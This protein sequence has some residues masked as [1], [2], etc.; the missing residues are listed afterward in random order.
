MQKYEVFLEGVNFVMKKRN[1]EGI[2]ML[3]RIKDSST[4]LKSKKRINSFF[5]SIQPE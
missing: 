4:K 1:Q 2:K 3:N 5:T